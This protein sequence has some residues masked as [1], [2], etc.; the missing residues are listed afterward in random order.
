M[1]K[2]KLP[3]I[4]FIDTHLRTIDRVH[5]DMDTKVDRRNHPVENKFEKKSHKM[6]V[7]ISQLCRNVKTLGVNGKFMR[8]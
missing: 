5:W 7:Y 1:N 3:K 8:I 4:W 6:N 2:K